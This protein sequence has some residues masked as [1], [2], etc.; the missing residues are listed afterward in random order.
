MKKYWKPIVAI[1]L[2]LIF[3]L[4][5]I[6][7]KDEP[8]SKVDITSTNI[9][10]NTTDRKYLDTIVIVGLKKLNIEN[11]RVVI[12]NV[13][14]TGVIPGYN[15]KAYILNKNNDYLIYIKEASRA[16]S[17]EILA[18]ELIHYKQYH[19]RRLFDLNTSIQWE[20]KSY[21]PSFEYEQR[22]WEIEAFAK[23]NELE[24]SLNNELYK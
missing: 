6:T 15:L 1:A 20:G 5:L 16:E 11:T 19:D 10:Y 13:E 23:S 7:P 22:P 24:K 2:I 17:I 3:L 8:F 12:R 4:L 18:H 14:N 9:V 21:S